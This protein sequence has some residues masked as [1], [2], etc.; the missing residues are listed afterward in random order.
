MLYIGD[1]TYFQNRLENILTEYTDCLFSA[2]TLEE[3]GKNH[4]KH[5]PDVVLWHQ[6]SHGGVNMCQSINRYNTASHIIITDFKN[7]GEDL[8]EN[9]CNIFFLNENF[10][11]YE[12]RFLMHKVHEKRR[13]NA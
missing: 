3:A 13:L 1:T 7:I 12:L 11:D 10:F 8:L 4:L 6:G 5:M 9:Q 2:K